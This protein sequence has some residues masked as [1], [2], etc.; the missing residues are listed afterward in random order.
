MQYVYLFDQWWGFDRVVRIDFDAAKEKYCAEPINKG[1]CIQI[2]DIFWLCLWEQVAFQELYTKIY[3]INHT[4][5]VV[6][7]KLLTPLCVDFLHAQTA[8]RFSTYKNT[9]PLFLGSSLDA[10]LKRKPWKSKKPAQKPQELIVYPT[11]RSLLQKEDQDDATTLI[12][13]GGSTPVQKAKGFWAVKMWSVQRIAV[14]H[15]QAF[16]DRA[17]LERIQLHDIHAWWYKNQRDP[18]YYVPTV[19]KHLQKHF[20]ANQ[21]VDLTTTGLK[22]AE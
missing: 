2:G 11:L 10:I 6:Y 20:S 8:H 7:K 5:S 22:F 3:T 1:D 16:H 17:N 21:Q 12:L 15:S 9:V 19:I 13:H 18:R 14:T 4:V